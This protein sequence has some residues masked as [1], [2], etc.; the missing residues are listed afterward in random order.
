[1]KKGKYFIFKNVIIFFSPQPH[2]GSNPRPGLISGPKSSLKPALLPSIKQGK[3]STSLVVKPPVKKSVGG[4]R[5]LLTA[6]DLNS[7]KG[8]ISNNERIPFQHRRGDL[9][10]LIPYSPFK[11]T[12][13]PAD[14]ETGLK[15]AGMLPL[16]SSIDVPIRFDPPQEYHSPP[17]VDPKPTAPPIQQLFAFMK[18]STTHIQP[19]QTAELLQTSDLAG[20]NP[21]AKSSTGFKPL[22]PQDYKLR[23][24]TSRRAGQRKHEAIAYFNAACLAYTKTDFEKCIELLQKTIAILEKLSDRRGLAASHNMSGV[25]CHRLQRYKTAIHHFKKQE[26]LCGS[27]GKAISQIN[28]GIAYASLGERAYSVH[29][30]MDA[31]NN[32][33][34]TQDMC[35]ESL[36]LGNLGLAFLRVGNLS[37]AQENL[38]A[39]MELCS[40][41]GDET[42]ASACLL[43]LGEVYSLAKDH[44]RAQFYFSNALRVATDGGVKDVEHVARVSLGISRGNDSYIEY[45]RGIM[46]ITV[47]IFQNI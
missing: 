38:E 21:T 19:G 13:D 30:L 20:T 41:C 8:Y 18:G 46:V 7:I 12:D 36:A 17:V 11:K 39:C 27:Y 40:I 25:C 1:M 37:A 45:V 6:G 4:T 14:E 32:S 34:M 47:P 44:M 31:L 26:S 22:D 33:R 24:L 42:G 3:Q 9:G 29:A 10:N 35:V 15:L 23:A 28:L 5:A 43:L 2:R 16:E